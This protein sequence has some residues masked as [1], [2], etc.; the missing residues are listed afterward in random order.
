EVIV[1]H[2]FHEVEVEEIARILKCRPGTVKSRLARARDALRRMLE[3]FLDK[4]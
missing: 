2:Y 4:I 3:P 1:L